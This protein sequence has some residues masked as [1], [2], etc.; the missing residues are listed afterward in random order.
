M[1]LIPILES[2]HFWY[3]RRTRAPPLSFQSGACLL[4]YFIDRFTGYAPLRATLV[5]EV[6][7]T[8]G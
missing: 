3:A 2:V 4:V 6:H 1:Y 5:L 8:G 7:E